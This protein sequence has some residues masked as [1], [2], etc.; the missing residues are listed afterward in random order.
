APAKKA[1]AKK[2]VAKKAAAPAKKATAKK[3]TAR[4]PN[5]RDDLKLISGVGPKIERML[6][7]QGV[8][9]FEQIASFTKADIARVDAKLETFRGRIERDNWKAQARA[10]ARQRN[11]QNNG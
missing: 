7:A 8:Y 6:Y 3:T 4:R 9:T 2:T 1:V 11:S 10:L 5:R